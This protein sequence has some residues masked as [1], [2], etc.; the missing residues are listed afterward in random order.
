MKHIGFY[1]GLIETVGYDPQRALL[2]IKLVN[3]GKVRQYRNVPEDAWYHLRGS[4]QPDIYY[5][6]YICGSYTELVVVEG[7]A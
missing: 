6:K 1:S 2:E 4:C 3:D 7:P 5:R